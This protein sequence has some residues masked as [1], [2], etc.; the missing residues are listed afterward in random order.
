M[1]QRVL[2]SCGQ[3]FE[4]LEP[5]ISKWFF[6]F[7]VFVQLVDFVFFLLHYELV[8]VEFRSQATT[9]NHLAISRASSE[10]TIF[11]WDSETKF[12]IESLMI[13]ENNCLLSSVTSPTKK[14]VKICY[15]ARYLLLSWFYW[16][17]R[18]NLW[19]WAWTELVF[20]FTFPSIFS[21][22]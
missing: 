7:E 6:N 10:L 4:S 11:V 14:S 17:C 8:K 13:R 2:N 5:I 3:K 19:E 1:Q 9:F 21:I 22:I 15:E 20:S 12:N 16:S 18:L